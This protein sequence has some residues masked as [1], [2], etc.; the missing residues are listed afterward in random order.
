ML[1]VPIGRPI[2]PI[3]H[4]DWEGTGIAPDVE[5]P[6]A[7]ALQVAQELAQA[8]VLSVTGR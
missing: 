1:G 3:T 7:A 8:K 2:N 5:A 6:A 4:G